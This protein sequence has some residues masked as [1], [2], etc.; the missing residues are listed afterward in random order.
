M[1]GE[2]DQQQYLFT[3]VSPES[4]VPVDHPLRS[5]KA[6]ADEILREM[7]PL[8]DKIYCNSGRYSIPPERLLK[9][10]ILIALFSVRSER[11][12]CEMLQYNILFRWF[13]DMSLQDSPMERSTFSLNRDRLLEHDVAR[14]FFMRV[15]EFAR[16]KRLLSDEHFTVDGTLI[17]SWASM[18]SVK[19]KGSDH[20]KTDNDPKNPTVNFR[21]QK[22]TN[23]TH[24]SSTDPE[25]RLAKKSAGQGAKLAFGLH[26]MTEN[27]NGLVVEMELNQASGRSE[28]K[29]AKRMV[30]R[31][32]KVTSGIKSVG[33]DKGYHCKRF[34]RFLRKKEIA[35]HIAEVQ[36][37]WVVG[38]DGRTTRTEGYRLSQIKRKLV[39]EGFG[40]M[41]T[42]GN[43]RKSRFVGRLKNGFQALIV[44]S[45]FNL[46]RISN[47]TA[48]TP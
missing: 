26:L 42:V 9:S 10:Q 39:E 34:V 16:S 31:Y 40:W 43:F 11:L 12:F 6:I 46:V 30:R 22:R 7:S 33:A 36:G 44:G 1:R 23:Q 35:P 5:V 2:V 28:V 4:M 24:E 37:R 20:H 19:P 21:G 32:L 38:L 13:L 27:R 25:A 3:S 48:A 8:F 17:E 14:E 41:K 47:L 18:K 29:G 15:V 45:A